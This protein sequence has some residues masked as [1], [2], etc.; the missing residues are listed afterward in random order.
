MTTFDPVASAQHD[1]PQLVRWLAWYD[2]HPEQHDQYPSWTREAL[3]QRI[4][5][6]RRYLAPLKPGARRPA[7]AHEEVRRLIDLIHRGCRER[8]G[9]RLQRRLAKMFPP[10]LGSK[11]LARRASALAAAQAAARRMLQAP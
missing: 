2:R 9:R 10:S 7:Y 6:L 1:L 4:A 11:I 3:E 8:Q 5:A